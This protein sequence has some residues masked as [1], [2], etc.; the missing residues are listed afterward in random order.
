MDR[1]RPRQGSLTPPEANPGPQ[2]SMVRSQP[3][4]SG[5]RRRSG[6]GRHRPGGRPGLHPPVTTNPRLVLW[7][8]R[9]FLW[10]L[11]RPSTAST[12]ATPRPPGRRSATAASV[13]VPRLRRRSQA[14]GG[15][16]PPGAPISL[17]P[18]SPGSSRP[19]RG[20]QVGG[21]ASSRLRPRPAVLAHLCRD[22]SVGSKCPVVRSLA[23]PFTALRDPRA[24]Q[25][26]AHRRPPSPGHLRQ[27]IRPGDR[28]Q[29]GSI[30]IGRAQESPLDV[31]GIVGGSVL[32][33]LIIPQGRSILEVRWKLIN[34][35]RLGDSKGK[36]FEA[37]HLASPTI[38]QRLEM[39]NAAT[40]RITTVTKNDSGI[41]R[42]EVQYENGIN[43]EKEF[44]LNVYGE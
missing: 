35:V 18:A 26:T 16:P 43:E 20:F 40:L 27:S 10:C 7:G 13:T 3:E 41:Y 19:G 39:E 4:V 23:G 14:P 30:I 38:T 2:A 5:A 33:P 9:L 37:F 44:R 42:A 21:R 6:P 25:L 11:P 1:G 8:G 15:G 22:T 31:N 29:K 17:V 36:K 28:T 24:S 32:L 12:G 34:K